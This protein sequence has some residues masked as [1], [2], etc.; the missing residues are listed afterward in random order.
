MIGMILTPAPSRSLRSNSASE[1]CPSVVFFSSRGRH[2]RLQGDWSSDVC[3]SDLAAALAQTPELW[4]PRPAP[5]ADSPEI[6]RAACRERGQF[7]GDVDTLAN[8]HFQTF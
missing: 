6:G 2:T 5:S 4:A 8:N 7:A 1:S 3:S